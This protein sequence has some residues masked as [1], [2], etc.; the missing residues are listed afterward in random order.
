MASQQYRH[1]DEV[2]GAIRAAERIIPAVL[3]AVG[4]IKSA[5]DLGGGTGAWLSVF[6]AHGV[7]D[8]TLYDA[9]AVESHLLIPREQFQ[10]IDLSRALPPVR[11]CD[12][13]ISVECAEHLPEFRARSVVEW[14]TRSSPRV[15]FSAATTQ[16]G[17]K[18]HINEQPPEY[19]RALFAEFGY[20]CRDVL[21]PRIIHDPEVPWWYRQNLLL[22]VKPGVRLETET[23]DFLPDDFHLVHTLVQH[24]LA[25][26]GVR[27]LL[28]RWSKRA[29][30]GVRNWIGLGPRPS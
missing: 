19:W 11:E 3:A 4:P 10:A 29:V 23:P 21:R 16:Q 5:V 30:L 1:V 24:R 15:V 9:A 6:R 13:A 27:W 2:S 20:T 7:S 17:G 22:F 18:G 25:N 28:R 26:P 12:L 8:V 14:L